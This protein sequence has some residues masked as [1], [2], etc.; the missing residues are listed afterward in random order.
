MSKATIPASLG[1][2]EFDCTIKRER[3]YEAD[4][5]E[6][7]VEDGFMVSDAVLKKP[8][9]IELTAFISNMPVTWRAKHKQTNR[10]KEVCDALIDLYMSGKPLRLVTPDKIYE[11][12]VITTLSIPDEAYINAA[13]V[14][15][16]L[17]QVT[18]T[19]A[20]T[21]FI[22]S[23]YDYSG[24]TAENSGS[25]GTTTETDGEKEKSLLARLFG[26]LFK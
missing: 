21:V 2:V 7:P 23:D 24:A 10:V 6:Y 15:I 16:S 22:A 9:T 25:S 17:K 8:L 18:V 3:N 14:T 12:M 13:E 11:N 26:W 1:G 5:P 4:V 20:E 19:R